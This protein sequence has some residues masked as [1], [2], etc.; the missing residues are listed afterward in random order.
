ML[1]EAVDLGAAEAVQVSTQGFSSFNAFKRA[2]GSAGEGKAWHHIVE[3]TPGN[4]VELGA[5][6]IH[7]TGN[8]IKLPHGAG[9]IHNR[10]SGYYSSKDFFTGGLT[11]RQWLSTQ[12]YQAQY[13]FGIQTLRKFG[14]T[15]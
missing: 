11:V 5:E 15:P 12:N 4:L 2:M 8:L 7:N 3:Q 13:D 14:W 9:S 10:V 1:N 6:T